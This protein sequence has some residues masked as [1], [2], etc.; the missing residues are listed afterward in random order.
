MDDQGLEAYYLAR[1][2]NVTSEFEDF[3]CS[4]SRRDEEDD[5]DELKATFFEYLSDIT[6]IVE[7]AEAAGGEDLES[8]IEAADDAF[9]SAVDFMDPQN[10]MRYGEFGA[11][12]SF[13]HNKVA[14]PVLN[15]L[16]GK[17]KYTCMF[18]Q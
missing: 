4:L 12:K 3:R 6:G 5:R 17:P 8:I 9:S 18:S 10:Y 16:N 13:S 14:R 1:I 7:E 2:K 15:E 11:M